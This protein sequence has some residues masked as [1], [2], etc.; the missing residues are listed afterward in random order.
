MKHVDEDL[1]EDM[2]YVIGEKRVAKSNTTDVDDQEKKKE[3]TEAEVE[4][5]EEKQSGPEKKEEKQAEPK[6]KKEMPTQSKE[7]E[8]RITRGRNSG[9]Y[10]ERKRGSCKSRYG[11]E[12]PQ[13]G[14][15]AK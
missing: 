3:Q 9:I 10:R 12:C 4:E 11:R 14:W 8:G 15:K 1:K 7:K 6:E 5:K 13:K 2:F